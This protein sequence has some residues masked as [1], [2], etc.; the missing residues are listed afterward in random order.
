MPTTIDFDVNDMLALLKIEAA[1]AAK[2]YKKGESGVCKDHLDRAEEL[3][4]E[5]RKNA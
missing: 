4:L 3:I 1:E 5:I 2:Q